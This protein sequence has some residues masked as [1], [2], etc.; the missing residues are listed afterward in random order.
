VA[1]PPVRL[2]NTLGEFVSASGLKQFRIAETEKYPHVTYFFNGGEETPNEGEDRIVIPSP[3]V[4]TY[5]LQPEMSAE[6]VA[7]TLIENLNTEKYHLAIVNFANPDMVGHTGDMDA[8]VKAIEFV[9][10]QLKKVIEAAQ[11]H[12]YNVVIIAD[13][14]N[15]DCMKQ[16]DGSAHTAHTTAKVPVIVISNRHLEKINSG[17]LADVSPTLLKLMGLDA[18]EEMSGSPLF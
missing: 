12:D 5:D 14:G 18:P 4:A 1:Y 6:G 15:A 13:H 17:I 2:K 8:A 9:D 10:K 7:D 3:K 16:P 11:D